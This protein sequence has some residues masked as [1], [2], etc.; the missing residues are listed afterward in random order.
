MTYALEHREQPG[1]WFCSFGSGYSGK[2]SRRTY[3]SKG[4][5]LDEARR[6]AQS[7]CYGGGFSVPMLREVSS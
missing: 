2:R 7:G 5:A 3:R 6:A 1:Y 4:V